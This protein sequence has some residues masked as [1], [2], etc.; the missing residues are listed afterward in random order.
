MKYHL[1]IE[2]PMTL[3]MTIVADDIGQAQEIAARL[4]NQMDRADFD[5][6][7]DFGT[8]AQCMIESEDGTEI[9]G[10]NDL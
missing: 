9:T 2:Q 5:K 7:A 6:Q 8:E 1:T 3:T 10:W 4:F